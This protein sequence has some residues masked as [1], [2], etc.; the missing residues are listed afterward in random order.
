M[1][2]WPMLQTG[3]DKSQAIVRS[4]GWEPARALMQRVGRSGL[5]DASQSQRLRKRGPGRLVLSAWGA[6][7]AESIGP[8]TPSAL[9]GRIVARR[10]RRQQTCLTWTC[11]STALCSHRQKK[12]ERQLPVPCDK[13]NKCAQ[14]GA[15]ND[16]WRRKA[17]DPHQPRMAVPPVAPMRAQQESHI[18]RKGARALP[19]AGPR[20]GWSQRA[21]RSRRRRGA[22]ARTP[23][24]PPSRSPLLAARRS[25]RPPR[26]CLRSAR[27]PAAA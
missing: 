1:C 25:R 17:G 2:P 10:G 22:A 18:A 3:H 9:Y 27:A 24:A 5:L 19:S 4:A 20:H 11:G 23:C 15:S 26:S 8:L 13:E 12:T 14:A 7:P 6:C 21:S 16:T